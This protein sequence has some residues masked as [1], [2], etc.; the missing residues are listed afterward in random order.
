MSLSRRDYLQL[1]AG[2]VARGS[3]VLTARADGSPGIPGPF[4]GKVVGV[5]HS[6]CLRD[7]DYQAKPIRE[8]LNRGMCELTGA[9]N[10][11]DAWRHFF[12]PADTV[13]IKIN[14]VGQPGICSS[15]ELLHA[16]L[17]ELQTAGVKA[18]N[19]TVYERYRQNIENSPYISWVPKNIRLGYAA[20]VFE[21]IQLKLDGYDPDC[22]VELPFT[23]PGY[24]VSDKV[25]SRSH[26]ALFISRDVNK[27]IN[28]P[29][30]KSHNAAGV[31]LALKN[32]SHGL[33]NNVSRTHDGPQLRFTEFIPAVV[34]MPAIRQKTVLNILDGTKGLCHGGPGWQSILEPYLWEHKT[35]YVATD[36]VALDIIGRGAIE[37]QRKKMHLWPL[38]EARTDDIWKSPARQ[39]HHIE[40]AG[41]A[42]LGE[43]DPAKID[44]KPVK[45]G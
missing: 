43:W 3:A 31:T 2:A 4:R 12:E 35:I 18:N 8:M 1:M 15:A 17:E 20:E 34:G 22:Y 5:S 24:D 10:A 29:V 38:R 16:I 19:I 40:S 44:F 41:Q 28:L 26:A 36:P 32:L 23:L 14:P 6:K 25:A 37:D 9:S 11:T 39:P 27:L 45:L 33:V 30:L 21:P 13:G 7:G 42:G